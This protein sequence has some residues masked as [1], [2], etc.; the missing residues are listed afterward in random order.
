MSSRW[1]DLLPIRRAG[2]TRPTWR[3]QLS[4]LLLFVGAY[5]GTIDGRRGATWSLLHRSIEAI[6]K[7][8]AMPSHI[9]RRARSRSHRGRG[10]S[11]GIA[12]ASSP[13]GLAR[14][15]QLDVKGRYQQF[16]KRAD[17]DARLYM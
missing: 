10:S 17:W 6:H 7:N 8:L 12:G 14:R 1:Q 4:L 15:S 9:G 13:D 16:A 2:A 3:H 5:W 11:E